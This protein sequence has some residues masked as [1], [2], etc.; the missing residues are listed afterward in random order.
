[1]CDGRRV[2]VIDSGSGHY[3][4][5]FEHVYVSSLKNRE[6]AGGIEKEEA[7]KW[8][9]KQQKPSVVDELINSE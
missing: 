7:D 5:R 6:A 9:W 4:M 1:M 2:Y 3:F 8:Q